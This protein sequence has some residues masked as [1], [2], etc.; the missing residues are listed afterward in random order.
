MSQ[1]T[2]YVLDISGCLQGKSS[3]RS[4]T[5]SLAVWLDKAEAAVERL[6]ADYT[7]ATLPLLRIVEETADIDAAEAALGQLSEGADT[8]IFYGTGGSSL[9]GQTLAQNGG[10]GIPHTAA[11]AP[12]SRPRIR[13]YDNLDGG[14]LEALLSATDFAKTR[15]V[16]TSKSG[17]TAETLAQAIAT[18]SAIQNAGLSARI[19]SL[20]LGITEPDVAGGRTDCERYSSPSAFRYSNITRASGPLFLSHQRWAFAGDGAGS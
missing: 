17:G 18:I 8:I 3:A 6:R 13:F 16:V 11:K 12:H 5:R 20:F 1:N 9:G 2:D 15:F 10:W 7:N 4:G 14:T 19:P